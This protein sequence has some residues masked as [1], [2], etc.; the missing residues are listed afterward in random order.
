MAASGDHITKPTIGITMGDPA[1][2]GAEIVV[3]ALADRRIRGL[4]RYVVY[5]LNE[6]LAYAADQLEV[7]P[8]WFRVQH[9]S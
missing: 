9:Y 8:Y 5:G 4:A 3:K 2:I 7:E 1:G 6:L